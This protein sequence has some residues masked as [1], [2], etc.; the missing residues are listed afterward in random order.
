MK[1]FINK[2]FEGAFKALGLAIVIY[3]LVVYY[4]PQAT[5]FCNDIKIFEPSIMQT[6]VY[7]KHCKDTE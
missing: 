1:R 2:F 7:K 3:T 6:Q 5:V 4:E